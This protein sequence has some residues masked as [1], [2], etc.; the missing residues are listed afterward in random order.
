VL[1]NRATGE[2]YFV[3]LFTLVLLEEEGQ[4][5][6]AEEQTGTGTTKADGGGRFDWEEVP[7]AAD[8]E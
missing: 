2:V 8:V 5:S 3:V 6:S 7:S 1:K 4:G